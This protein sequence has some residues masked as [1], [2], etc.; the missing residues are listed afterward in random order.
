[1]ALLNTGKP[2]EAETVYRADLV[3]NP[4]NGWALFGLAVAL[5]AQGRDG[6]AAAVRQRFDKAWAH[7]DIVLAA[8][9]F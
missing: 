3:R 4:E 8:S 5:Q 9:A 7:A 1:V 2:Q 6:D